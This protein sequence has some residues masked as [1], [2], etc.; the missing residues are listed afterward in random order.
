MIEPLTVK[1]HWQKKGL[2][3]LY[4]NKSVSKNKTMIQQNFFIYGFSWKNS[5]NGSYCFCVANLDFCVSYS[6][7]LTL[8]LDMPLLSLHL[9]E[10]DQVH[11]SKSSNLKLTIANLQVDSSNKI[12]QPQLMLWES[13]VRPLSFQMPLQLPLG[14]REVLQSSRCQSFRVNSKRYWEAI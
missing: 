2:N 7:Q 1:Y 5:K 13:R 3:F 4:V 10:E 8:R 11:H 14:S 12:L 9:M 6:L